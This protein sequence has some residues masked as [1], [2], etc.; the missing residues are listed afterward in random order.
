MCLPSMNLTIGSILIVFEMQAGEMQ[1]ASAASEAVAMP[2][3]LE[4]QLEA[5]ITDK[6]HAEAQL[7]KKETERMSLQASLADFE[8]QV[9]LS[10]SSTCAFSTSLPVALLL[11]TEL[12]GKCRHRSCKMM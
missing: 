5:A 10:P 8:G 2:A 12:L 3:S 7:E 4:A 11:L 6:E 1:T 9:M